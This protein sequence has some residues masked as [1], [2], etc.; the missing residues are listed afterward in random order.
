MRGVVRV[1][2]LVPPNVEVPP[3][4]LASFLLED[5]RRLV[6]GLTTG[7]ILAVSVGWD[8]RTVR[9][10]VEYETGGTDERLHAGTGEEASPHRE[11]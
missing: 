6:R 7:E 5:A 4:S 9:C 8:E 2:W 11:A 3:Q 10:T 1:E